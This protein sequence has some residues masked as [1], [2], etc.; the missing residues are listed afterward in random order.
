MTKSVGVL[1]AGVVLSLL[2][3]PTMAQ[4]R[5]INEEPY[6]LLTIPSG[7]D[8]V[9]LKTYP[10]KLPNR[11][12]PKDPKPTDKIRVRLLE[13]EDNR[14]FEVMWRDVKKLEFFEDRVLEEAES[15]AAAGKFDDAYAD[16]TY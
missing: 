15:L 13:D 1:A 5:L 4:E 14:D 10:I 8:T 12:M 3:V 2:S 6:D 16:Y 11:R 9:T 7:K